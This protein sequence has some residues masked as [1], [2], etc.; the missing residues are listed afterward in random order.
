[1]CTAPYFTTFLAF[2][3]LVLG[4]PDFLRADDSE[5]HSRASIAELIGLLAS[6]RYAEREGAARALTARDDA[7]PHLRRACNGND[8]E[9]R[10]RAKTILDALTIRMNARFLELGRAGRVDLLVE[11]LTEWPPAAA[12]PSSWQAIIEI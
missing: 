9:V 7:L 3:A 8:A 6:P 1:M 2:I 4:P 5:P 11:W 10:R 12:E